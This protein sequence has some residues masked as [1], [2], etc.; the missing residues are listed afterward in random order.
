MRE[1]TLLTG[2]LYLWTLS[3]EIKYIILVNSDQT[4]I[5]HWK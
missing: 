1:A 4:Q 5:G 3:V 2:M